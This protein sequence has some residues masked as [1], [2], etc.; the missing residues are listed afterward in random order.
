MSACSCVWWWFVNIASHSFICYKKNHKNVNYFGMWL[1]IV[2]NVELYP[3]NIPCHT[4]LVMFLLCCWMNLIVE[5]YCVLQVAV[6]YPNKDEYEIQLQDR[7]RTESTHITSGKGLILRPVHF[8]TVSL[9]GVIWSSL[10]WQ[11]ERMHFK[12]TLCYL[13]DIFWCCMILLC[14][15]FSEYI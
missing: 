4:V 15:D 7:Q 1:E 13:Q 6:F 3:V 14:N 2:E 9:A 12:N 11:F 5:L 10:N 8:V